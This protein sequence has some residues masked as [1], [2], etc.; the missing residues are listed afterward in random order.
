[1]KYHNV[2]YWISIEAFSKFNLNMDSSCE[3]NFK[4]FN[5]GVEPIFDFGFTV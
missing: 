3:N 5:R 4:G 1:M 2:N